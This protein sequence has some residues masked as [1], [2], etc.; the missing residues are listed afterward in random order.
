MQ[1][2]QGL[3]AFPLT[4]ADDLGQVNTV[5]LVRIIDRLVDAQV[6][7][8]GLLGSTGIYAYLTRD[9]RRRAVQTASKAINGKVPL[10]VGV[11]A[12]RTDDAIR[13]AQDAASEGANGLL[14]APVSYTPLTDEEVFQHFVAVAAATDIPLCIYNNPS[15]THFAFSAALLARLAGVQNIAAV[16]M[17]LPTGVSIAEELTSLRDTAAGNL[18]IG[19][20]GDWGIA[21]AMGAGAD[22]FYSGAAGVLPR[23]IMCLA[24]AAQSGNADEVH[25]VDAA[26]Q[27]LWTL[28]REFGGLRVFYVIARQLALCDANPPLPILPMPRENERRIVDALASIATAIL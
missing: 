4:P 27:P 13:L 2:F 21:D 1:L 18:A 17:P 9:E 10:I 11:G 7:S 15:T 8:I 19:Y 14:L 24:R 16:K 6:D 22:A 28:C 3:S 20:S 25:R 23:E 12:L 5:A 26:F